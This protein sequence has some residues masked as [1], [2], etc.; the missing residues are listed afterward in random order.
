MCLMLLISCHAI[1][2]GTNTIEV[3]EGVTDGTLDYT[4]TE[5]NDSAWYIREE[6]TNFSVYS[7]NASGTKWSIPVEGVT[8]YRGMMIT[9]VN[10]STVDGVIPYY[11][12]IFNYVNSTAFQYVGLTTHDLTE[13]WEIGY[14]DGS[15]HRIM[16]VEVNES[17]CETTG[18]WSVLRCIYNPYV[19]HIL[20]K[21]WDTTR[22]E[23]T[24][25]NIDY[26]DA[27][28]LSIAD[29]WVDGDVQWG[30]YTRGTL[31][32]I[33]FWGI[34]IF[35][36]HYDT[37]TC[38]VAG[39]GTPV[40]NC[41]CIDVED[42]VQ[43]ILEEN[44]VLQ[45]DSWNAVDQQ[46]F[47]SYLLNGIGY[48]IENTY[49]FSFWN[50]TAD[51]VAFLIYDANDDFNS[52]SDWMAFTFDVNHN[53]VLDEGDLYYEFE[54]GGGN[55]TGYY[56]GSAWVADATLRW[57]ADW[58]F[59]QTGIT[60]FDHTQWLV[61]FDLNDILPTDANNFSNSNDYIGLGI[62]G[63]LPTWCWNS[64]DEDAN[65]TRT[66]LGNAT[67]GAYND[68]LEEFNEELRPDDFTWLGDFTLTGASEESSDPDYID[69]ADLAEGALKNHVSKYSSYVWHV[70]RYT[71]DA[72]EMS[73][74]NVTK[75]KIPTTVTREFFFGLFSS[76]KTVTEI[77]FYG[78]TV[79]A[80][81]LTT[82][83]A[84]KGSD[85]NYTLDADDIDDYDAIVVVLNP[86]Y[87]DT[88]KYLSKWLYK[89]NIAAVV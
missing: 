59:E 72:E 33:D 44:F 76:T 18:N 41:P 89:D 79:S 64:W 55:W 15:H 40:I 84:T 43:G 20:F 11:G 17:I 62:W 49:I 25:W 7:C 26:T 87:L 13:W 36:L 23:P 1:F 58:D 14:Y 66:S 38:P 82:L 32:V 50:E 61:S 54:K 27:A 80:F 12:I 8:D 42:V 24:V 83:T 69:L 67:C 53:H 71:I 73:D 39:A 10:A 5:Y 74:A 78:A 37:R 56:D 19:G 51:A 70:D 46:S 75:I 3:G 47:P 68:T 63:D 21:A 60:R 57:E 65:A 35:D 2:A 22:T 77:I 28:N 6:Y 34:G 48:P 29:T 9:R 45:I 81:S 30:L 86:S 52:S 4:W 85:G 31:D 88:N 16:E